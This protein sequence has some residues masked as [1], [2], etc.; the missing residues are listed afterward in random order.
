MPKVIPPKV[1]IHSDPPTSVAFV[2]RGQSQPQPVV[3][4]T[5]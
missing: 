1:V 5:K 2:P 3:Y 4:T